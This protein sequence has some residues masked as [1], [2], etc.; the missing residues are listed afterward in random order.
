MALIDEVAERIRTRCQLQCAPATEEQIVATEH[1]LSFA[2][3]PELRHLYLHLA[4]GGFGPDG[5]I[6]GVMGGFS[7]SGI[8]GNLLEAY[9]AWATE[10]SVDYRRYERGSGTQK[11]YELPS[12]VWSDRLLPLSD[13]GCVRTAY[14][15]KG[16]GEVL[17]G[18]PISN[19][20]YVLWPQA[21]SLA[22]WLEQW[23][24]EEE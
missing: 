16:T 7:S 21:P 8:G 19:D 20:T 18:G 10:T 3:P 11:R 24:A 4:N 13:L 17:R 12:H 6:I 15:D 22:V 5:G 9:R 1:A 23:I 2:L 14:L